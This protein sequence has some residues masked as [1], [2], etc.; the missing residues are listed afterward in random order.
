MRKILTLT[1][2]LVLSAVLAIAQSRQVSGTVKDELGNPIPFS[3]VRIKGTSTGVSADT[4]GKFKINAV[5][6]A[7]LVFTAAGYNDIEM[8]AGTGAVTPVLR[9]NNTL[10]EV[11]VTTALGIAKAKRSLGYSTQSVS[12]EELNK[13]RPTDIA[14][15]LA[16]KVSGLQALGTPSSNFGEGNVRIRGAASLGGANPIYVVDGTVVDLNSV[17]MDDVENLTVLKGPSATALYG[18]RGAGGVIMITTKKASKKAPS[19]S[20]NSLTEV[21]TVSLLPKYQDE[22]G[23]GY[24]QTWGTFKYNPAIH[25]ASY[26][27]FQGQKLVEY[28]ADESWGPRM[29]GTLVREWFSWFPG[30]DF[31]IETPFSPHPNSVKDFYENSIRLNNNIVF[32]GGGPNA[33]FRLSYNNRLFTLPMPNTSKMDHIVNLKGMVNITPKLTVS[34]NLNFISVKQK[35]TQNEG[36]A[37]DNAS[38]FNQWWQ[39]QIDISKLKNYKTP[40]GAL[41]SWNIRS[42]TDPRPAYWDNPYYGVY[43]SY[44]RDWTNRVYG[45]VTLSYKILNDLKASVIFRANAFNY[46]GDK[47]IGSGGLQLDRYEI[48]NGQIAEYNQEFLIEYKK[49]FGNFGLEQYVGGNMRQDSKKENSANTVGGLSVPGIYSVTAS[50]DRPEVKNT[51]NSYR[52]NSIYARGTFDYK[53]FIFLDYSLRNDVS[54]SLPY[55]VNGYIYPSISASFVFSDLL[56]NASVSNIMN[57]GKIRAAFGRVGSD[58]EAYK[59]NQSY[60]LGTP[61][62]SN[63]T[64]SV[65]TSIYDQGIKPSLSKE[66]EAGAELQFFNNRIGIDF[67]MYRK[68]GEDQ[69]IPLSTTPSSGAL[70]VYINAGLIRSQGWDLIVNT[71]PVRSGDFKWDLTFNLAANKSEV[72]DLDSS[73]GLRN[74]NMGTASFGPSVNSRVGEEWGTFI[75]TRQKIDA[76]SGLPIIDADGVYQTETNQNLGHLLPDLTGGVLTTWTYKDFS[77]SGTFSFQKGGQ[78]WSL[79][80]VWQLYSGLSSETVGNNDKGKPIRDDV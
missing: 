53:N 40:T 72:L 55:D 60:N 45:D 12:P 65:P 70:E 8:P 76:K 37:S 67:S 23:G 1:A 71:T 22:Y 14:A 58:L 38:N 59:L 54:S 25:P 21:G 35:G 51:W 9:S 33:N 43:E 52:L 48:Q 32:D 39:R 3:T 13:I 20:I 7:V 50:K 66:Y 30:A 62:G 26:A 16:G 74:Y 77:L 69:I 4:E 46:G 10:S 15:A 24:S 5:S 34:T 49:R 75:G 56:K 27:A 64:M 17:N 31:G 47:R 61:Y 78:F 18:V 68:D 44:P 63:P 79:T 57:F 6:N 28:G 11:V 19:V 36:Y 41:T 2:V 29:D 80:R 73:K 42:A